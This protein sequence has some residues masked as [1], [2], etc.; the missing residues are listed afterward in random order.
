[1]TSS[2]QDLYLKWYNNLLFLIFCF[3]DL[4]L[5]F[6]VCSFVVKTL[7]S[8]GVMKLDTVIVWEIKNVGWSNCYP[9]PRSGRLDFHKSNN[10]V[11]LVS[12]STHGKS[13]SDSKH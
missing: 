9:W 5:F 4:M 6:S 10:K 11:K 2:E 1:M 7:I 12:K 3:D 13:T 8:K